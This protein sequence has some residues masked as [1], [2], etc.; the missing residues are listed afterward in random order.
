MTIDQLLSSLTILKNLLRHMIDALLII[1]EAG[2]LLYNWHPKGTDENG[3]DDLF[4]FRSVEYV[5][6]ILFHV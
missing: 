2:S 1:N 6:G 5:S 4:S 3:K